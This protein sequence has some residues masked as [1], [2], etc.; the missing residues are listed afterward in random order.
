MLISSIFL[1]VCV[2]AD[3][4]L[5]THPPCIYDLLI[6]FVYFQSECFIAIVVTFDAII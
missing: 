2:D 1:Y 5:K 4:F 6:H 3:T